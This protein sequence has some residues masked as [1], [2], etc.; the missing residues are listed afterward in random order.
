MHTTTTKPATTRQHFTQVKLQSTDSS[1]SLTALPAMHFWLTAGPQEHAQLGAAMH[2]LAAEVL[3]QMAVE[4]DTGAVLDVTSGVVRVELVTGFP[5][6]RTCMAQLMRR[7]AGQLGLQ[8]V[9]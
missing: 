6:E 5:E 1:V 4:C 8:V 7:V 2:R 9:G 3:E